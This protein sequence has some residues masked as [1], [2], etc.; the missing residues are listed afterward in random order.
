MSIS[1]K[2]GNTLALSEFL[3]DGN[4]ITRIESLLYFGVQNLTAVLSNLK[5]DGYLIKKKKVTMAKT[6]R[7]VNEKIKCEHPK[8]LPIRDIIMHEWWI[9]NE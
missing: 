4:K 6:L 2:Y 9:S 8:N 3:L 7:R 5:K 1:L